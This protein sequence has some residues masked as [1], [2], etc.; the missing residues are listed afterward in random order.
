MLGYSAY[1]MEGLGP[2]LCLEDNEHGMFLLA[3]PRR[4]VGQVRSNAALNVPVWTLI[5]YYFS[6]DFGVNGV[7]N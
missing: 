6:I 2:M 3:E 7:M 1:I 4:Q 5:R